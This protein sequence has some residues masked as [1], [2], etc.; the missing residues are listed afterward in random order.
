MTLF[1]ALVPAPGA[2]MNWPQIDDTFDWFRALKGCPQDPIFHAEGDV[3]IHTRLVAEALL[4]DPSWQ[5]LPASERQSLFWAALLHDVAK[6]AT[7]R[8]ELDGRVVAPGHSRRGQI[9]ARRI[10]ARMSVPFAQREQ[11]CHLITHH[12]IPFYLLERERPERRAHLISYQTRCDLLAI[13]AAADARGRIC[14]DGA[15][16]L[17]NI[18]LFRELCGEERCLADPRAFASAHSR[19]LYFRR[20]DRS[21]DYEAFDNWHGEATLLS[22]LPG[23]GKDTWLAANAGDRPVISLDDLRQELDVAPADAQGPVIAAAREQARIHLRARQPFIWN[24]T[25]ISRQ[26]RS[27]LIGLFADYKAKVRIVYL[28]APEAEAARRN[29]SR[30]NPVPEAAIARML[31]RWEPPDLT[32]CHALDVML[33]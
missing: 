7:T 21:A 12:Q 29:R 4:A 24:A 20:E 8:I 16:L 17:D 32:E 28:E 13:L 31:D 6:P 10:L 11:I 18:A 5:V 30:T 2:A 26:L 27:Q 19:F 1:H 25:N 3:Y 14:P 23:S 22:G 33:T 15:R 9:M